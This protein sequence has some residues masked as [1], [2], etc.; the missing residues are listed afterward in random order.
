MKDLQAPVEVTSP[1]KN[2][3]KTY[4]TF[5]VYHFCIPDWIKIRKR[6]ERYCM[7]IHFGPEVHYSAEDLCIILIAVAQ[8]S[9][10]PHGKDKI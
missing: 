7:Y 9:V 10:P 1:I 5:F 4:F 8:P 3:G 2:I 6:K